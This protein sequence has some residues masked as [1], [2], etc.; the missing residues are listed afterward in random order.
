MARE[1]GP[2]GVRVNCLAPGGVVTE[3]ER[4]TMTGAD[5][6]GLVAAQSVKRPATPEDLV[7][8]VAFI[9]SPEATFITGQTLV[10]DGGLIMH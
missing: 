5:L 2:D 8:Y 1:L 3:V 9:L 6:D 10:I 7:G 4:K